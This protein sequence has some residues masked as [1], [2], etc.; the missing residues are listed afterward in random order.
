M[1]EVPLQVRV[2]WD[3]EAL[4]RLLGRWQFLM[5]KVPL[6]RGT[7]LIRNRP[8]LGPYRRPKPVAL[9]WSLGGS[10]FL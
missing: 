6:G 5:S 4:C 2:Y 9:W 3:A 10:G 1:S 8:T 7:S